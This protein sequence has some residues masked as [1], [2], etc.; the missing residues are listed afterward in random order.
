M[1]REALMLTVGRMQ[2]TH[3]LFRIWQSSDQRVGFC[4]KQADSDSGEEEGDQE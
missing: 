3:L 2:K 1:R 4:I